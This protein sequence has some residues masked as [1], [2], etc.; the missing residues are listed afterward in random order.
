MAG[1]SR[2]R[3]GN[4]AVD[5]AV[6]ALVAA[7][8]PQLNEDLYRELLT[9]ASRLMIDGVDRGDLKIASGAMRELRNSFA[10]FEPHAGRRK[11]TV[12]G[13]ARTRPDEDA[14]VQAR[15]LGAALSAAGWMI[16][17]GG[18]PGIMTAIIEGAGSDDSFAAAIRLPFEQSPPHQLVDPSHLVRFRYFFTRKLTF[19]NEASAYALF[20]GGFGTLDET[21]E[22]F[23]LV[24]TG[25]ETPAP[26]VLIDPP[27]DT[28]WQT[29]TEFIRTEL[30]D[31][32]LVSSDDLDLFHLTSSVPEAVR[33]IDAFFANYHSMRWVDGQLVIR[34]EREL[35]EAGLATL[36]SEF[37]DIVARPIIP[38]EPLEAEVIDD[39]QLDL[40]RLLLAFDSRQFSRLH[41]L[42][43]RLGELA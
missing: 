4:D 33:Y 10:T 11:V 18:G 34:M 6:D 43:R 20:P 41:R 12:F 39:D 27:G 8:N 13:S 30:C 28:Y 40:P 3:T 29:I 35:P 7:A 26:I 37:V 9:A 19:M 24:Q 38:T 16:I 5:A 2:Y 32:G 36:N 25:K 15:E 23:T 31:A 42:V 22:L 17:S 21:F 14:Y 1:P